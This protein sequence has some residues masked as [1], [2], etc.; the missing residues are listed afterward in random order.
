MFYSSIP[1]SRRRGR[2]IRYSRGEGSRLSWTPWTV[3]LLMW[4][5]LS[6]TTISVDPVRR[7]NGIVWLVNLIAILCLT[8]LIR[9]AAPP[10]TTTGSATTSV[11]PSSSAQITSMTSMERLL[12]VCS[13]ARL[14]L[15]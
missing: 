2:R 14:R 15:S 10:S 13:L 12:I 5:A 11:S 6:A 8:K 1:L 4:R 7:F 3:A 9:S